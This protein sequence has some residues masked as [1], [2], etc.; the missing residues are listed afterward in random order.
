MTGRRGWSNPVASR[1]SRK[2][3]TGWSR[4][5]I[6]ATGWDGPPGQNRSRST[7]G[8]STPAASSRSC[9]M[10]VH[11]PRTLA[12]WAR[13]ASTMPP[14]EVAV[15]A[16]RKVR[17]AARV[18]GGQ[19]LDS[20]RATHLSGLAPPILCRFVPDRL[21]LGLT[22][23]KGTLATSTASYLEH[24]FDLLGSGLLEVRHG[25]QCAGPSGHAYPP[26][27]TV[28][29]DATGRW[30]VGRVN[31]A[32]ERSFASHLGPRHARVSARSTGSSTSSLGG[33][34]RSEPGTATSNTDTSRVST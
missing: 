7:R 20:R 13:R 11:R 30:L 32:N 23:A 2:G 33:D 26:S 19:F 25:V 15:R 34:G 17:A 14:R 24:R 27:P 21:D 5:L 6:S 1:R 31:R 28:S 8:V 10:S 3:C 4:T 18:P 9:E 29:P 22:Q 12:H 16:M